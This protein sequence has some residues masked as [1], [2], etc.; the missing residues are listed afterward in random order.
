MDLSIDEKIRLVQK[1]RADA[2][3]MADRSNGLSFAREGSLYARGQAQ[4]AGGD[5]PGTLGLR[6]LLSVCIFGGFLFLQD[7]QMSVAGRDVQELVQWISED[8]FTIRLERKTTESGM[9]GHADTGITG[10]NT[11]NN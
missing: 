11:V 3:Q 4:D 2:D 10:G 1:M 7:R 6:I 9:E 5:S 8:G